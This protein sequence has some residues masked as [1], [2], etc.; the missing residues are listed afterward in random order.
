MPPP[1][2]M[3]KMKGP[4]S[5]RGQAIIEFALLAPIIFLLIFMIVDFGI[6]MDR[7][8]TLQSAV[9]EG[10]RMA[11]V[12]DNISEV[13]NYTVAEA[14]DIIDQSQITFS[15]TDLDGNGR[16]TDAGDSVTVTANFLWEFPILN[17]V[18]H[19]MTG[20]TLAVEMTPSGTARL[21]LSVPG[22]TECP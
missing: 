13:C 4:R 18:F 7:R 1:M 21:E 17:E 12:N 10:A 5:T 19:A 11:A 3:R 16:S 2:A 22:E 9:R 20:N 6:T 14:Q 8:I 15:Y